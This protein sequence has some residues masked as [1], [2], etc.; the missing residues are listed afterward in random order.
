LL[1]GATLIV[2][3]L[4]LL[5]YALVL[6][7][8]RETFFGPFRIINLDGEGTLPAWYSSAL[9][10]LAAIL[11]FVLNRV[12][13]RQR[14]ENATPW[15]VL[16]VIFLALSLDEAASL[17]E[18]LTEPIR[19]AIGVTEG[20]LYFG[21]VVAAVPFVVAVALGFMPL[22]R[23]LP[24][25]IARRM[26]LA[27]AIFVFGAFGMELVGASL[28]DGSAGNAPYHLATALEE[29][30]EMAGLVLFILALYDLIAETTASLTV[31]FEES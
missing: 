22:L 16:A 17:H 7:F 31:R 11:L 30:G 13:L 23:R 4:G 6:A 24:R 21:W 29:I 1:T 5:R 3:G 19:N 2:I 27:G 20:V 8:G 12:S 9:M 10:L 15:L 18:A 25:T 28:F 26:I 14:P